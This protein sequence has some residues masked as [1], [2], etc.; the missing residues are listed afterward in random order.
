MIAIIIVDDYTRMII[1]TVVIS[2]ICG[3]FLKWGNPEII[4]NS[5][6]IRIENPRVFER[7]P[8]FSPK[9]RST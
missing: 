9:I 4:Q 6:L 2:S 3:G 7:S 5:S 8:I 1:I